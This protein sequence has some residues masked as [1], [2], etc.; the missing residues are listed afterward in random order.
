MILIKF[1]YP[2]IIKD[3]ESDLNT[4]SQQEEVIKA[5]KKIIDQLNMEIR[6][7]E[8]HKNKFEVKKNEIDKDSDSSRDPLSEMNATL[9]LENEIIKKNRHIRKLLV[10]VKVSLHILYILM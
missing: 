6:K 2:D 1:S 9:Q 4:I 5:N 10:D 8:D 3:S 7:L